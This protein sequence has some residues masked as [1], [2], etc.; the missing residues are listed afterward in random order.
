MFEVWIGPKPGIT[1]EII[2]KGMK[3]K[4]AAEDKAKELVL[5]AQKSGQSMIAS[6]FDQI[7]GVVVSS[8]ATS[9]LRKATASFPQI[10]IL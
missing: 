4:A 10:Q 5:T 9:D 3:T 1:Q 7:A 2:R 6:V 8:F